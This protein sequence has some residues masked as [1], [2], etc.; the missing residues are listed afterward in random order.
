[1]VSISSYDFES[2]GQQVG[3]FSL[4]LRDQTDTNDSIEKVFHLRQTGYVVLPV[5]FHRSENHIQQLARQDDQ[6]HALVLFGRTDLSV[7]ALQQTGVVGSLRRCKQHV[8]LRH[9]IEVALEVC[10]L[11][12]DHRV[13]FGGLCH[14]LGTAG[15]GPLSHT[16]GSRLRL[17]LDSGKER[18]RF[19]LQ[20]ENLRQVGMGKRNKGSQV[21]GNHSG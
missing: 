8:P 10:N 12:V 1:M 16:Q 6:D 4:F 14:R 18:R 3:Y 21:V 11:Q 19:L 2:V 17:L 13:T 9:E 5:A 7:Q 20:I 15:S